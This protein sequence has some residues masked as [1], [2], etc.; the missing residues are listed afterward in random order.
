MSAVETVPNRRQTQQRSLIW[1]VRTNLGPERS[2]Y[3]MAEDHHHHLVCG[4]CG[5]T[6]HVPHDLVRAAIARIEQQSGF[7][8]ATAQLSLH[9]RCRDCRTTR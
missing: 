9:G 1:D 3:E 8:L 2:T 6:E 4:E 7:D 5:R